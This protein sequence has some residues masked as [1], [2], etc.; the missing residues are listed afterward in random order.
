M[1][2]HV[3]SKAVRVDEDVN[4]HGTGVCPLLDN[5]GQSRILPRDGLSAKPILRNNGAPQDVVDWKL[6]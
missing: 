2:G 4:S 5:S 1:D 6:P 3:G